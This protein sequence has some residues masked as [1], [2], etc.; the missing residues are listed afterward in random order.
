LE[1]PAPRAIHGVNTDIP[2]ATIW[3]EFG[4]VRIDER[5]TRNPG[6]EERRRLAEVNSQSSLLEK[7]SMEL[8]DK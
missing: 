2:Q 8:K 3:E 7:K 4:R 5:L 1:I 6:N